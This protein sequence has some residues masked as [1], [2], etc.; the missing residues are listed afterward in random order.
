MTGGTTQNM[1]EQMPSSLGTC[2]VSAKSL[3]V[4]LLG[5]CEVLQYSMLCEHAVLVIA[6]AFKGR[7]IGSSYISGFPGFPEFSGIS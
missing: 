7:Y 5:V 6:A 2:W 1:V 3:V 4:N